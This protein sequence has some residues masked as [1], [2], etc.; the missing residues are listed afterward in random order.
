M[1]VLQT[2]LDNGLKLGLEG[3]YLRDF[4]S[5]RERIARE[6]R[7]AVRDRERE[8]KDREREERQAVRESQTKMEELRL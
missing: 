5:D 1:D 8:E 3:Q 2:Y 6:D 4:I 7:H